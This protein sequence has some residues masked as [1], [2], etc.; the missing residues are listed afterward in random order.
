MKV[1]ST[2][3]LSRCSVEW[4][5]IA[6]NS[7]DQQLITIDWVKQM[8]PIRNQQL[9]NAVRDRL[10]AILTKAEI[11]QGVKSADFR[12]QALQLVLRDIQDGQH[13]EPTDLL[14]WRN[15][16]EDQTRSAA[17]IYRSRNY[18]ATDTPW[19][20]IAHT[21]NGQQLHHVEHRHA[22]LC[23]PCRD[24]GRTRACHW[25]ISIAW[26]RNPRRCC[27]KAILTMQNPFNG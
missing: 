11:G 8:Y 15:K 7:I 13:V 21:S 10:K 14:K 6:Q 23:L 18:M 17:H 16:I 27:P 9:T 3:L 20:N 22:D 25:Q 26:W 4:P 24:D 19:S 5:N 1:L 12:G 2:L